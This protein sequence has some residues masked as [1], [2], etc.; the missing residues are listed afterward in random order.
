MPTRTSFRQLFREHHP[1]V[2]PVAHDALSARMITEAG[3]AAVSIGGLAMLA[4]QFGLPDLG[5]ATLGEMIEGTRCVMRGTHLPI[6]VDADDGYGDLKSVTH[7]VEAYTQLGVGSLI[8]EDQDR[9]QKRPG[10]SG[11]VGVIPVD[12]MCAKLNAAVA[13]RTDPEMIILARV[14]AYSSEGLDGALRRA[15]RYLQT[16]VDGIFV[17]TL[18]SVEELARVGQTLRGTYQVAVASERLV[19]EWPAPRELYDMGFS[20]V[21]YPHLVLKH[22]AFGIQSALT[23][24]ADFASGKLAPKDANGPDFELSRLQDT[25]G[26]KRWA[27]I[28][29][30][31]PPANWTDGMVREAKG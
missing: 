11:F 16:G 20:Q 27:A 23:T 9:R 31:N 25:L 15:D 1:L 4:S 14:D 19:S 26:R 12:E 21:V 8:F 3:F 29:E 5:I 6:G 22:T 7:T 30:P 13:A 2:S 24:I 28:E 10:D 17:S 18:N